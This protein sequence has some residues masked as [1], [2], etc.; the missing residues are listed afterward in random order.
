LHPSFSIL[1]TEKKPVRQP[2][3]LSFCR[4]QWNRSSC[5]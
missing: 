2:L 4:A 5:I 3:L 1:R